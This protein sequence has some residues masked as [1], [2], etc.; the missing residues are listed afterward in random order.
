MGQQKLEYK[1]SQ[2]TEHDLNVSMR[3]KINA[4]HTTINTIIVCVWGCVSVCVHFCVCVYVCVCISC[5]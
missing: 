5:V 1:L 4:N 2:V 3:L